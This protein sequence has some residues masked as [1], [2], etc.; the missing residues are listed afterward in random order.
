MFSDF[1]AAYFFI[2]IKKSHNIK[3]TILIILKCVIQCF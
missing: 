2:E 1:F 3:F